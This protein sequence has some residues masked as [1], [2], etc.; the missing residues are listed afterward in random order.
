MSWDVFGCW[1]YL[2][3]WYKKTDL[4]QTWKS[5]FHKVCIILHWTQHWTSTT[6]SSLLLYYSAF[7]CWCIWFIKESY[8]TSTWL[9]ESIGSRKGQRAGWGWVKQCMDLTWS[10]LGLGIKPFGSMPAP[11][12]AHFNSIRD[13]AR[14][15]PSG[16]GQCWVAWWAW[17]ARPGIEPVF[18]VASSC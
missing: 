4:W 16:A 12:K 2:S 7:G 10:R 18:Q 14:A 11:S 15:I 13:I 5:Y 3:L 8:G 6:T 9:I 1:K 17:P